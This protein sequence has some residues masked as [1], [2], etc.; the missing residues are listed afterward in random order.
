MLADAINSARGTLDHLER[1]YKYGRVEQND[2]DMAK[3]VND[4]RTV[5]T[6]QLQALDNISE[7]IKT[8]S[9]KPLY[10]DD[11]VV[12]KIDP[13]KENPLRPYDKKVFIVSLWNVGHVVWKNRAVNFIQTPGE[14]PVVMTSPQ[15]IQTLNAGETA[16]IPLIIDAGGT[17]GDFLLKCEVRDQADRNCFLNRP[18]VIEIP[19]SVRANS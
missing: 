15:P 10:P 12:I 8:G 5:T 2:A 13:P 11:D 4:L 6:A 18:D 7:K 17:E 16:R 9:S 19:V 1:I 3:L 14:H